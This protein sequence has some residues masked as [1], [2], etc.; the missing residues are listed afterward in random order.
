MN[1]IPF[2]FLLFLAAFF[3]IYFI[4]PKKFQKFA[5]LIFNFYYINFYKV[6]FLYFI[7][8]ISTLFWLYNKNFQHKY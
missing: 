5:L 4:L 3:P 8:G 1:F 2:E 6:E 7:L